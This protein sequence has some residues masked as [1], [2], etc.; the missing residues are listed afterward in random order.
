MVQSVQA[1]ILERLQ[2]TMS[3]TFSDLKTA[4][5]RVEKEVDRFYSRPTL[6]LASTVAKMSND[7]TEKLK[8]ALLKDLSETLLIQPWFKSGKCFCPGLLRK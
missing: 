8:H 5:Q 3:S 1:S 7:T 2:S 4:F 6:D